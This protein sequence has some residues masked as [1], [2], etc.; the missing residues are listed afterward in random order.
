MKKIFLLP[1]FLSP[2]FLIAQKNLVS[3]GGFEFEL[4]DWRGEAAI[5]L[6]DKKF[7][8]A[9]C[10]VNQYVGAEWKGIDQTISIPKN[11]V[12]L[13]YTSRCV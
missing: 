7:G 2:Y 4:N 11:T 8:N 6:Y 9:S 3:N 12:C 10:I 5:S 1:V 13:L